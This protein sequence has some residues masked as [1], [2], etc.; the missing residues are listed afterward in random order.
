MK[1]NLILAVFCLIISAITFAQVPQKI[2]YQAVVRGSDNQ[3]ATNQQVSMRVSIL[4]G[5]A[6]GEVVY[7][8]MHSVVTNANGLFS[9][10]IGDGIGSFD[11]S[12]IDWANGPYFVKTETDVS[13][14]GYYDIVSV[15]QLLTVPYAMYAQTAG[16][17]P[18]VSGFLSEETDPTVPE[19]AKSE[20]K[21]QYDYSEIQNTP[22]IP[23][24]QVITISNDTIFLSDGGFV[25]LPPAV[26]N[27]DYN[28]L[29]NT[30]EIPTVYEWAQ[31]E[32]KPAYDYSEIA[33]TPEIPTVPTVVSA[34][35]NDANYIAE[36]ADPTVPEW[37]K[38]ET[39]PE[40]DYSEIANT[41]EIPTVPTVVSA[42][43]NDANYLQAETQ[44]LSDVASLDNSVNTQLKNVTDPTDD[45]DAV[46]KK[47]IDDIIAIMEDLN[48]RQQA[49]I[50][51][52][53]YV[54]SLNSH[55]W[56][57]LGLPSG[58]KWAACNVGAKRP[59]EFGDYYA[60]GE[61]ETKSTYNRN[62]YRHCDLS[63]NK[64]TKYCN[65]SVYGYEGLVDNITILEPLDDAATA[66]WGPA[67][68]MPTLVEFKELY[69]NC[70]MVWSSRN[71]VNGWLFTGPNGNSVF[72]PAAGYRFDSA[73]LNEGIIGYYFTSTLFNEYPFSAWYFYFNSSSYDIGNS[74][75]GYGQ[76]I[77]PVCVSQH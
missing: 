36:E 18:D 43:E 23:E 15:N 8:E 7:T 51:S 60:W 58:T 22:E 55:E 2:S 49:T 67:W 64:L 40:Y 29:S 9:I 75:R 31:T 21:P 46:T 16:N 35:E 39:K 65:D 56:V 73:T 50:D 45:Q 68:R 52:L 62:T 71:G 70:T 32:T 4:R 11:F 26:F 33:N 20:S 57:E 13:G 61:T 17:I 3:L 19:W 24:R 59:E 42:F 37:A 69:D 1:K 47:Y 77:R 74:Y 27:G 38:A 5:S 72:F 76:S 48:A 44:T 34:F 41:P 12:A 6:Y 28:D 66:N 54:L 63:Y 30:P 10:E 53:N 25:K 14:A